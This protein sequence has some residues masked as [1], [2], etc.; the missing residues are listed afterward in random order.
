MSVVF[1]DDNGDVFSPHQQLADEP[2]AQLGLGGAAEDTH[3]GPRQL[4]RPR[5]TQ[6]TRHTLHCA[7]D[8]MVIESG[9][10]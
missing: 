5:Y 8:T 1:R 2:L 4:S 10:Q 6:Q 3:L 9:G 7:T